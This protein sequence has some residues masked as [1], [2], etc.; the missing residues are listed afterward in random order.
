MTSISYNSTAA[1]ALLLLTGSSK[2]LERDTIRVASGRDVNKASDNAAYW[3]IASSMRS[4]GLSLSSAQDAAGLAAAT[5]DT[6]ALGMQAA[7]DIVSQIQTRLVLSYSTGVDRDAIG[8]EIAQLKQQLRTV[9]ESSSFNG[10]NWLNVQAGASAGVKSLVASVTS[11]PDGLSTIGTIDIDTAATTLIDHAGNG[12]LTKS[13]SGTT[14]GGSAYEYYLLPSASSPATGREIA[15]SSATTEADLDGMISATSSMLSALTS[16]GASLGATSG[17]ISGN[18]EFL[19]KLQDAIERGIGRLVDSNMEES[20][21]RLNATRIQRELQTSGLN[22]AN[23][24]SQA[25]L[26]LFR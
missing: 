16:A 14:A 12:I 7:A 26:Q 9:S 8:E 15:V 13:Y 5:T 17:R 18:M 6:A 22:I 25:T 1:G 23:A 2:A 19:D 20:A 11:G 10:E 24:Q 21:V 3:S 4:T